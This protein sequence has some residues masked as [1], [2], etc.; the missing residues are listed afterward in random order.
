MLRRK[1]K[2]QQDRAVIRR[3][4]RNIILLFKTAESISNDSIL[5]CNRPTRVPVCGRTVYS[6]ESSI[7]GGGAFNIHELHDIDIDLRNLILSLRMR[8][9]NVLI[10]IIINDCYE[11]RTRATPTSSHMRREIN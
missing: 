5:T 6:G 9:F 3:D 2:D 10:I 4:S 7:G 11:I 8:M 1:H